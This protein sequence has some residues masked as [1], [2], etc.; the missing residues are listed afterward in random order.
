[1]NIAEIYNEY[2]HVNNMMVIYVEDLAKKE[3]E[4]ED[5]VVKML[6]AFK[7]NF[8]TLFEESNTLEGDDDN[9][10][11]LKYFL[12]DALLFT[13]DIVAFYKAKEYMRIKMRITNY[14][15]KKRRAEMFA[16]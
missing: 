9:L 1:M 5:D 15:A 14:V 13:R 10:K 12:F 6:E 7:G 11:D 4:T 8:E 16:K 2:D 3:F